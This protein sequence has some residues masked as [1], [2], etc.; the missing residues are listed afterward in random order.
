MALV[1][2]SNLWFFLLTSNMAL[3]LVF[4]QPWLIEQG[5]GPETLWGAN[6]WVLTSPA[7]WAKLAIQ[8][9][10][11]SAPLPAILASHHLGVNSLFKKR[12]WIHLNLYLKLLVVY[13]DGIM[14]VSKCT[15]Y[16][17][18]IFL[19]E[20]LGDKTLLSKDVWS[21]TGYYLDSE[22]YSSQFSLP[23]GHLYPLKGDKKSPI[24]WWEGARHNIFMKGSTDPF[25]V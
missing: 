22:D 19:L 15:L 24:A 3:W 13:T 16:L 10:W 9:L 7:A 1:L 14:W 21:T 12:L 2:A 8:L 23:S 17:Q 20:I 6:C 11:T 4:L 25:E 5:M 18:D